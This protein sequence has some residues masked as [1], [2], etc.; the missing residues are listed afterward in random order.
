MRCLGSAR[1]D[2]Q[3]VHADIDSLQRLT[4]GIK[5]HLSQLTL[6]F[7]RLFPDRM[8]LNRARIPGLKPS[9]RATHRVSA[10]M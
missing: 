7:P 2:V 3:R 4:F 9:E 6:T 8:I 5:R 1:N 10:K